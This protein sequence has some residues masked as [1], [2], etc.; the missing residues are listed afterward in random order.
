MM[1][2]ASAILNAFPN[3]GMRSSE[4]ERSGFR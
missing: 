1:R 4:K 2:F 3:L